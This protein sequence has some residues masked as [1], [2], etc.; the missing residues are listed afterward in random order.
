V[1]EMI[2]GVVGATSASARTRLC[3]LIEKECWYIVVLGLYSLLEF[4]MNSL[5]L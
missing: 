2:H 4:Y 5:S 3:C 1:R